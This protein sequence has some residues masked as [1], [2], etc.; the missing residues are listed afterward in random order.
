M[1]AQSIV[2]ESGE[3]RIRRRA[4]EAQS[5]DPGRFWTQ[6]PLCI[7]GP[8]AKRGL[9]EELSACVHIMSLYLSIIL[10]IGFRPLGLCPLGVPPL[11][12]CPFRGSPPWGYAPLGVPSLSG[13]DGHGHLEYYA[14]NLECSNKQRIRPDIHDIPYIVLKEKRAGSDTT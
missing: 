4:S 8:A 9:V 11:G 2:C 6:G 10:S 14:S 5:I 7:G 3:H 13:L 12:L 1:K